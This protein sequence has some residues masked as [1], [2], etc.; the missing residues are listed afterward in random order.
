MS[1]EQNT[2][3]IFRDR[4]FIIGMAIYTGY[5]EN[6]KKYQVLLNAQILDLQFNNH[7]PLHHTINYEY[8]YKQSSKKHK[9]SYSLISR[10][11]NR[12]RACEILNQER[13]R[14]IADKIKLNNLNTLVD[15]PEKE[16]AKRLQLTK[17]CLHIE[18]CSQ[19]LNQTLNSR[20]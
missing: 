14:R 1:S 10:A 15:Q 12:F 4:Y 3:S 16:P 2:T 6:K 7:L 13:M 8:T 5:P 11:N 9:L 20:D 18:S 19:S 17:I